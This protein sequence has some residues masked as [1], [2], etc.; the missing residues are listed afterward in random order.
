M[1]DPSHHYSLTWTINFRKNLGMNIEKDKPRPTWFTATWGV[2]KPWVVLWPE[3]EAIIANRKARGESLEGLE[4]MIPD[5]AK[6][7]MPYHSNG[8]WAELAPPNYM[9]PPKQ[10]IVDW[11]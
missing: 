9:A 5:F 3:Y 4:Y 2:S 1:L 8:Y 7:G 6:A 11:K 10:P